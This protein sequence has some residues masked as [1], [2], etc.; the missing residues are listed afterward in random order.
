MPAKFL[1]TADGASGIRNNLAF[2]ALTL[3]PDGNHLFVGTENALNQDGP[4]ATLDSGTASRI[5]SYDLATGREAG[6]FVYVTDLVADA[7][8]PAGSFSTNGL[9]ELLALDNTGS[10]LALERS[11]ST[12]VG[13]SIKLFVA[14]AQ[15]ATDVSGTF[16]LPAAIDGGGLAV[17]VGG[18]VQKQLLL[19]LGTLGITL[20]NVEGMSFGPD[21]ADGRK[22]LVLVSDDNFAS[23]Q[24][25][26]FIAFA[27]DLGTVPRLS[28][29]LE[30]PSFLR[31]L[32][33]DGRLY[34]GTLTSGEALT[35]REPGITEVLQQILD[36]GGLVPTQLAGTR[37][38]ALDDAVVD[39]LRNG[40]AIA[41]APAT[42]WL[43]QLASQTDY[44]VSL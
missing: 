44:V 4:A 25:T 16:A 20:D 39:G 35:L 5:I 26:Q 7:P 17:D 42:A 29:E 1:P 19:D 3:S 2:E 34:G 30:T 14:R 24:V 12:G 31:G 15:G 33:D 32:A 23:T 28:P 38:P 37:F 40:S 9:V 21:L 8:A 36:S 27:L 13:N 6:E 18:V 11:F 41:P 43:D 22:T 10:F